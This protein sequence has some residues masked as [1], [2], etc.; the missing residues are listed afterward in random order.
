MR[1]ESV[2]DYAGQ[3]C[4]TAS[5]KDPSILPQGDFNDPTLSCRISCF[6]TGT[7]IL[8][9]LFLSIHAHT[10]YR[11]ALSLHLFFFLPAPPL[12]HPDETCF[13][14]SQDICLL[15]KRLVSEGWHYP[16]GTLCK[17]KG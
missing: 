9:P 13:T 4:L 16:D 12:P 3:V 15:E 10:W 11:L 8:K 2:A 14:M 7:N 17:T 6:N 5:N 1:R